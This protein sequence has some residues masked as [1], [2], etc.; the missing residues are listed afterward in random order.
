METSLFKQK[1]PVEQRKKT[2]QEMLEQY[3]DRVPVIV[4]KENTKSKNALP[5]IKNKYLVPRALTV[6][7]FLFIIRKKIE[8][9]ESQALYLLVNGKYTPSTSDT[10]GEIYDLQKDDDGYLYMVYSTENTFGDDQNSSV[11]KIFGFFDL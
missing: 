4:E 5:D 11:T 10:L 3:P 9:N 2:T 7:S 8:L 6:G 1:Y